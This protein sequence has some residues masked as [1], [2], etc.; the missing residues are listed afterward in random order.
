MTLVRSKPGESTQLC[1]GMLLGSALWPCNFW[2]AGPHRGF[3][4]SFSCLQVGPQRR[5]RAVLVFLSPGY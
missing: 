1:E 2:R 4:Y 5:R 3:A